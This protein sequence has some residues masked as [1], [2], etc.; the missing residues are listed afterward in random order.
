MKNVNDKKPTASLDKGKAAKTPSPIKPPKPMS[1]RA[2]VNAYVSDALAGKAKLNDAQ[3]KIA[4]KL[5][6]AV[7][8]RVALREQRRA[9]SEELAGVHAS[10]AQVD[11]GIQELAVLLHE[12][13]DPTTPG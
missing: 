10:L 9:K 12:L 4:A 8:R 2:E 5:N 6:D 1:E 7:A 13:R 11:G 3:K